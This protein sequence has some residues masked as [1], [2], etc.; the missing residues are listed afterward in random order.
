MLN[1]HSALRSCCSQEGELA[2]MQPDMQA[3]Q[4]GQPLTSSLE[5]VV[6]VD[7][8]EQC[9]PVKEMTVTMTAISKNLLEITLCRLP[10]CHNHFQNNC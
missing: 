9:L 8:T 2:V 10:F 3:E 5:A 6:G 7:V 1:S 4:G